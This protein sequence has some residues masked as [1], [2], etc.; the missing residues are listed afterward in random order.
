M[1][2]S[3]HLHVDVH[4]LNSSSLIYQFMFFFFLKYTIHNFGI[5]IYKCVVS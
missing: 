4:Y 2:K 5:F 1:A 3:P